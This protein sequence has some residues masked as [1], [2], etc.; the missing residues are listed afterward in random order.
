M[1][2]SSASSTEEPSDVCY[3][4]RDAV[5][6]ALKITWGCSHVTCGNCAEEVYRQGNGKCGLCRQPM[7]EDMVDALRPFEYYMVSLEARLYQLPSPD[8]RRHALELFGGV[9]D[10]LLDPFARDPHPSIPR[11]LDVA[12][13]AARQHLVDADRQQRAWQQEL[14]ARVP[15]DRDR[16]CESAVDD[17]DTDVD[18]V[19]GEDDEHDGQ[20]RSRRRRRASAP[21][22]SSTLLL[23]A[24]RHGRGRGRG[25]DGNGS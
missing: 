23:V 11:M 4:C 6:P 7:D 14:L 22:P 20:T 9:L 24:R 1:A 8:A 15:F 19:P 2:S 21:S 12:V 18:Y 13:D 5:A 16:D 25:R 17:V 3:V 10:L